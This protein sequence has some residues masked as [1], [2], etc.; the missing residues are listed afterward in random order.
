MND[1]TSSSAEI[2]KKFTKI[3]VAVDGSEA[4]MDAADYAIEIG[5]KY[6]SQLIA[7]Y[8]ILSDITL[9]GPNLPPHIFEIIQQAQAFRSTKQRLSDHAYDDKI[10]LRTEIITSTT[11]GSMN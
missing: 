11:V 3:L 8:V 6:D 7:L 9:F 1:Y 4:S 5:R 2:K 10:H